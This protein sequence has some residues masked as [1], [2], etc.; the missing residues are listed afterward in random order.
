MTDNFRHLRIWK[1]VPPKRQTSLIRPDECY[2]MEVKIPRQ[3]I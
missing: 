1:F 2:D 3:K